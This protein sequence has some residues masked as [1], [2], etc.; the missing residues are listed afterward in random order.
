MEEKIFFNNS[1]GDK[2][3]GILSNPTGNKQKPII[4]FCHGFTSSKDSRSYLRLEEVLNKKDIS[5]FRFDFYGHGESEGSLE[6]FTIQEGVQDILSAIKCLKSKGYETYI[7][8]G[9]S[10][11]GV[12]ALR[13]T[14]KSKDVIAIAMVCP[15]SKSENYEEL[16]KIAEGIKIP[17][18]I[19]HGN[20]DESVPIEKSKKLTNL[21]K[22][23]KL[24]IV[25][26]ADHNYS[27]P[28]HFEKMIKLISEFI[29][30]T[31]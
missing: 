27:N 21:I 31:H 26:G 16:Y 19:V 24:E 6:D 10:R 9:K 25:K 7:V 28:E 22:N 30:K 11:G 23:S 8:M 20:K 4:I 15:G 2:L 1:K 29:I 12:C 14:A 17:T 13:A 18:L 3:C 5:I